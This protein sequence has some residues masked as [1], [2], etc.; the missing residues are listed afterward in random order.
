MANLKIFVSS[1]CYDLG[2]LR[3]NLRNFCTGLGY[4]PVMSDYSDVLYDPRAHTHSSC[5]QE[6]NNVD[7]LILVVGSRFGGTVIPKALGLVD[8]ENARQLSKSNQIFEKP[9]NLSITQLEVIKAIQLKTPIFAFVDNRVLHDH[10]VYERNKGN[11]AVIDAITF[12]S[13]EK[14]ETAKYIFEFI[15]FLRHLTDNNSIQGFS[16]SEDIELHLRKQ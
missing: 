15:N 9:D 6:V 11:K 10:A 14:P 3:S 7:V 5:I 4:E 13:I 12:P 2:I 1:T 16:K 8:I